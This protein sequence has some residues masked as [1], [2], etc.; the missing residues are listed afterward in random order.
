MLRYCTVC[1]KDYDFPPRDVSSGKALICPGYIFHLDK[2]LYIATGIALG[3]FLLQWI[4]RTVTF[5]W[6]VLLLPAGAAAGYLIFNSIQGACLGVDIVFL[7]RH[8]IRDIIFKLIG[9]LIKASG[10]G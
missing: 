1:Q 3:A 10:R 8:I 4:T 5:S 2:M 9:K 6:G 7:A